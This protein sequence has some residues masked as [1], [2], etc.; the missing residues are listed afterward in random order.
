LGWCCSPAESP[1]GCTGARAACVRVRL[2]RADE[3]ARGRLSKAPPAGS[4][5]KLV[6]ALRRAEI[7]EAVHT[8]VTDVRVHEHTGRLRQEHLPAVADGGDACAP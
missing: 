1:P 2:R 4:D 7:L 5:L 3:P 8:Q 6:D